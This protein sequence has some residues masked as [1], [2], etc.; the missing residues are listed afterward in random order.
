M[1]STV[2]L[3]DLNKWLLLIANII[4]FITYNKLY[5]LLITIE[6][7]FIIDCQSYTT[8]TTNFPTN[9]EK[10]SEALIYKLAFSVEM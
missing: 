8:P 3:F 5:S 6:I 7:I 4:I 10:S 9:F 2:F 1:N